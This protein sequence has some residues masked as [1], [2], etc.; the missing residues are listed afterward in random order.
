[1]KTY[2]GFT[3]KTPE[4]LQLDAGAFFVNYKVGTDTYKSA[5]EEEKLLGATRDGGEFSAKPTIRQISVDGVKGRAKGLEA[6]DSWE[7]YLSATVLELTDQALR[8]ALTAPDTAESDLETH[9]VITARNNIELSDYYENVTWVGTISG[10]NEPIIIQVYNALNT[11][12]I[13]LTVKDA[14]EGTVKMT[15]Y[16]H[17]SQADLDTPP[18]RIYYPKTDTV[19]KEEEYESN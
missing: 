4:S 11:D 1:M 3:K 18:F 7:V 17:Y 14:S 12:G 10:S 2:S 8:R 13:T 9:S 5:I 6:L 19:T 15:F 16:G